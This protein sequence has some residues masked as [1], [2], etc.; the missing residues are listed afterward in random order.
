[1]GYPPHFLLQFGGSRSSATSE[2]WSCGIRLAAA[3]F[4]GFDEEAYL[5]GVGKDALAAWFVRT[6]SRIANTADLRYAKFNSINPDGEYEEDSTNEYIWPTPIVGGSTG[7]GLNIFQ[8]AVCLSW[9]TNAKDRGLASHGR[10]YSPAPAV[11]VA[12]GS[13]LFPAADALAMATSAALLLNTL[14]VS[15]G[16]DQVLRPSIVSR[17]HLNADGTYGDGESQQI[18]WVYV[19]NRV[20]ILRRRANS[21]VAA[22]SQVEVLY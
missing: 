6:G 7:A 22:T 3:S 9:R 20:D 12:A 21:L 18:D 16:L 19:D 8:A 11:A 13:G 4:A 17:G 10:I 2:I 15:F 1:M 5:A 14:D